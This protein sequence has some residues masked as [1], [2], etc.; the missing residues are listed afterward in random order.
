M[1]QPSNLHNT[2]LLLAWVL[3]G[4]A[5]V[6]LVL[7]WILRR[8]SGLPRGEIVYTD[9][10]G[11]AVEMLISNRYGLCG[12]P[13]YILEGE[14]NDLIPVEVKSGNVPRNRK[15]YRSHLMQLAVYFVLVED[16][17]ESP[18]SYGLIRYRDCTLRITNTTA[19]RNELFS[20]IEEMREAMKLN[21]AQRNHDQPRRCAGCSMAHACDEKLIQ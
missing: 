4:L 8:S 14:D 2:F 16:I 11:Q 21:S 10:D 17:L 1:T 5:V 18:V 12:K 9:A 6:G 3:L 20:I 13:D 7:S 19:L 15:P